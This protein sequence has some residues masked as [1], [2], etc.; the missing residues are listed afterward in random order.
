MPL[1]S[2]RKLHAKLLNGDGKLEELTA[3]SDLMKAL[4]SER[5]EAHFILAT[6]GS[7]KDKAAAAVRKVF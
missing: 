3:N 7:R 5:R 4:E 6:D 1:T 2:S